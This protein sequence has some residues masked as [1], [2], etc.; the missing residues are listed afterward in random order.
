[1]KRL[2]VLLACGVLMAATAA[3]MQGTRESESGGQDNRAGAP[4]A[5]SAT[6]VRLNGTIEKYDTATR[7]LSLSTA[8]GTERFTLESATRLRQGWLKIDDAALKKLVGY[9]AVVR[10]SEPFGRQTIESV[11]VWTQQRQRKQR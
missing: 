10:Y 4:G 2:A 7:T 11:H 8:R 6:T 5:R 9:R 1:M 3:H